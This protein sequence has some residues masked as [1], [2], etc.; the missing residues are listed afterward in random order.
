MS[1]HTSDA[2][3][4]ATGDSAS[5]L[6]PRNAPAHIHRPARVLVLGLVA[7]VATLARSAGAQAA[8]VGGAGTS[9]GVARAAAEPFADERHA[10]PSS[11]TT[12]RP[13]SARPT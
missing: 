3:R 5:P 2:M 10:P 11:D 12:R 4:H 8:A 9:A 13:S 6:A 7:L 1:Q